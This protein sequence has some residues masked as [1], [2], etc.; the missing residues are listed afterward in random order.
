MTDPVTDDG[1]SNSTSDHD[2]EADSA[3][4]HDGGSGSADDHPDPTRIVADADV[5]A[6][7]L[8]VGGSARDALDRIRE[9]SW[10][11]LVASDPL[12]DD[13]EAVVADLSD[14]SLA[15][16]WRDRIERERVAVEHPADDHPG[17]ASAYQGNA[18]HLLSLDDSLTGVRAGVGM[19]GHVSVSIRTPDAFLAVF[20]AAALYEGTVA[21]EYPGPDR[22]PRS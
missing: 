9:H 12:L 13:A 4:L 18:A 14:D 7:D 16:D 2:D 1:G 22:E 3:A 5:L 21:D 11:H 8:L 20:D 17:L 10:L 19:Q 15:S 6:A